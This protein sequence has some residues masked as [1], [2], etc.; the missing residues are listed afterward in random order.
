VSFRTT[1]GEFITGKADPNALRSACENI[2]RNAVRFTQ[3]GTNV[4]V[5]LAIDRSTPETIAI[6]SVRDHG[7]GVP[8]ESL[9][10][11]FQPFY[12]INSDGQGSNGNGLG[13]AIAAEAIRLHH[14]TISAANIRPTGL[15]MTI[16]LPIAFDTTSRRY[17]PSQD[18]HKSTN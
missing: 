10:A 13:L 2:I 7:P 4:E 5:V 6:V 9:K 11:I 1:G 18:E 17:E 16:R 3:P 8:E 15:E 14:G 12:R